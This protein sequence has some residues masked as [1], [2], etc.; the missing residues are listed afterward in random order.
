[1]IN[2]CP[3]N[4]FTLKKVFFVKIGGIKEVFGGNCQTVTLSSEMFPP[5]FRKVSSMF[6]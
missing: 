6:S 1:M 3:V 5:R 4:G 2:G